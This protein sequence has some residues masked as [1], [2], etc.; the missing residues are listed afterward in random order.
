[1]SMHAAAAPD[2]GRPDRARS[3]SAGVRVEWVTVVWMFLEAAI[4]I[5]AGLLSRSILLAAFGIDSLI[6]L[7]S[8]GVLLW[9][10]TVE[11]AHGS[12]ERVERAERRAAWIVGI[13]LGALCL[14]IVA[15]AAWGLVIGA[16]PEK[17]LVGIAVAI[18]AVVGMP[19]LARA[20][21][22]IA[23]QID[24]AA[25]R[26]D[27]ACSST[28]GAMAGALLVGLVANGALGWWWAEYLAALAF[29]YWLIPE[30]RETLEAARTG[31]TR[32]GCDP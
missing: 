9:R 12:L 11:A 25:L 28:C 24:S 14:Y 1:M 22:R 19:L 20:K 6:E 7:L 3:I 15:T 27:A 10:L 16:R 18:A 8:G 30:A 2:Y 21:R 23:S 17:S 13:A 5:G 32:C 4:A 29:L 31:R 26:G